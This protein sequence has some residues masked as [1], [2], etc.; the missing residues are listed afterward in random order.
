M[1][2][3]I[4]TQKLVVVNFTPEVDVFASRLNA[5]FPRYVPYRSD[6]GAIAIDSMSMDLSNVKFYA[7]PP[8]S[9]IGTSLQQIHKQN[10]TGISVLA[11]TSM[12][13]QSH[14]DVHQ[15]TYPPGT[16]QTPADTAG[17]P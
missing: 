9:V 7:F 12:L 13:S 11:D 6:P 2:K 15:S 3:D 1:N 5:Q 16:Q 8:V 14:A 17:T 4:L 10:A